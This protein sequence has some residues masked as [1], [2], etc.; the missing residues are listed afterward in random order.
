MTSYREP[1]PSSS[2]PSSSRTIR[3]AHRPSIHWG[4]TGLGVLVLALVY[5]FTLGAD[6]PVGAA[7]LTGL[8]VGSLLLLVGV[9]VPVASRFRGRA[10]VLEEHELALLERRVPA[11]DLRR[12]GVD[13]QTLRIDYATGVVEMA[14]SELDQATVAELVR[15]INEAAAMAALTVW[16]ERGSEPVDTARL[17]WERLPPVFDWV[18]VLRRP[19]EDEALGA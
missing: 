16:I 15:A 2:K 13:R 8:V 7:A 19:T 17:G 3:C 6:T 10:L 1:S 18:P 14:L 11:S 5:A 12:A 4:W 9:V